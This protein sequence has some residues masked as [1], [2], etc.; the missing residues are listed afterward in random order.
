MN[1]TIAV[2]LLVGH[3]SSGCFGQV[4]SSSLTGMLVDPG[5]AAIPGVDISLTNQAT[6][7]V[8]TTQSNSVG[9]FRFPNLQRGTYAL[10]ISASGFK[11]YT[12]QDIVVSSSAYSERCRSV[13]HWVSTVR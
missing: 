10:T 13:G 6:G 2:L 3:L 8:L 9:L 5:D 11:A 4:V 1:R 7:A 12:Q